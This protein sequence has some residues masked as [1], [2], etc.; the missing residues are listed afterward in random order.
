[1]G[2]TNYIWK[3]KNPKNMNEILGSENGLQFKTKALK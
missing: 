1:M 2:F 3:Q